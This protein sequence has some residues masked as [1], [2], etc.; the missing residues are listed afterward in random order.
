MIKWLSRLIKPRDEVAIVEWRTKYS[1]YR[2]ILTNVN[3]IGQLPSTYK[4]PDNTKT[5]TVD[6]EKAS[7]YDVEFEFR[8]DDSLKKELQDLAEKL[9][10]IA[11]E[12]NREAAVEFYSTIT[13]YSNVSSIIDAF[14][15]EISSHSLDIEPHLFAFAKDLMLNTGHKN[16]VKFGIAI[17]GLCQNK[18]I[19]EKLKTLGLYNEFTLYVAISIL[20]LSE[21]PEGDLWDLGRRVHGWGKIQLIERLVK[22]CKTEELKD[23]LIDDGYK[24]NIHNQHLACLC[25]IYGEL[26]KKVSI[27]II[28]EK[29][30][31]NTR[32]ILNILLS[33]GPADDIS[34]YHNAPSTMSNFIKHSYQH[35]NQV[36]DFILLH[37]VKL[38]LD[39]QFISN[40][41]TRWT[42]YQIAECLLDLDKIMDSNIWKVI[43]KDILLN[44]YDKDYT[45]AR[46][47]ASLMGLTVI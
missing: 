29:L 7:I 42:D 15:D 10:K 23:W 34:C 41:R 5:G 25:A 46:E 37:K 39:N 19:I 40:Q 36:K 12:G 13:K 2:H 11:N 28:D 35:A 43:V 16:G 38:Y 27:N 31:N 6:K 24:N 3:T 44:P 18:T 30:Y 20:N 4:L 1:L 9:K 45:D 22:I 33:P 17:L 47:A 26:D 8:Q 14:L 32:E 21:N